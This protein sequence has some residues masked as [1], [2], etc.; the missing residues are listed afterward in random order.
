MANS[1]GFTQD[2]ISNL[3]C[4]A[5][6]QQEIYWDSKT[7]S[8]GVRVTRGNAKSFIFQTRLYG[9]TIRITIGSLDIWALGQAQSEAR[10][11]KV[12]T[13]QGTDPREE[14]AKLTA[15]A[16]AER[17]KGIQALEVWDKYIEARSH[18][19]GERH[20]NDHIDMVRTG[21][22]KVTRGLRKNQ[23]GTKQAG[24][25]FNLLSL[26]LNEL[27]RARV[28][29]WLKNEAIARPARARQALS[30][31]KAF[32]TWAGDQPEY[33]ALADT[34]ACERLTRELPA[35]KAKDDCLQ[36]EQLKVW[37]DGVKKISN[38]VISAYLQILLLTG[39]RRN[40]LATMKWSDLDLQ[41]HTAVIRDKVEGV[42]TIPVT[43]YVEH[44]LNNLP[45]VF[46]GKDGKQIKSLYV[47]ASP[48]AKSGRLTEPRKAHEQ[49]IEAAGIPNLSI[50]G[51]RRSFGT[52]AEWT[53]CPAGISAQIMGHKPSAIAEKH[54][55][56]RPIDLLRQ[57]HTKIEKFVLE[58]AGI[59]QPKFDSKRLKIVVNKS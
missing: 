39:A 6:K 54:Y 4:P 19:W 26:P 43:P 55:R 17:L 22:G 57:W 53:E 14:R 36:K 15:K 45:R 24:I 8:L 18:Q 48:A 49:V 23:P 12:L 5:G 34:G 59:E 13:D 41:W 42:R 10:R 31:L 9:K 2:R 25:L 52:L 50:H 44:L 46:K 28:L 16:H 21:G 7:P 29:A 11:L 56:K 20:K 1:I 30:A 37:F 32:L 47:F 51:L 58:E 40:E 38:P 33:S 27:N 3:Q 35:K